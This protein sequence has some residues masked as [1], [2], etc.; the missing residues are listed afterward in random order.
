MGRIGIIVTGL[1]ASVLVV[2]GIIVISNKKN[3]TAPIQ[4]TQTTSASD[5]STQPAT[6]SAAT[7]TYSDS[8]FSPSSIS[9]N[10]GDTVA[11]VNTSSSSMQFD[12]NPHPVHTDDPELN[13]GMIDAGQTG[14][15]KVVTKGTHG[16]HN[17]LN[18]SQTGTIIVK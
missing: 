5:T 7:I 4:N 18:T 14:T 6:A 10:S 12:S 17:H 9:V 8:G 1:V 13:V 15:V 16:Y 3:D 11:I 2:G